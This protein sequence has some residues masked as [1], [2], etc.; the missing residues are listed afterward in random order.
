MKSNLPTR[1]RLTK[2]I[3]TIKKIFSNIEDKNRVATI[4]FLQQVWT[5]FLKKKK[6]TSLILNISS[7]RGKV[8]TAANVLKEKIKKLVLVLA[9]STPVIAVKKKALENAEAGKTSKNR[10]TGENGEIGKN[11]KNGKNKDKNKNL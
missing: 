5:S 2:R 6:K 1:A 10:E 7:I 8:I 4:T 9:T 3:K 11:S